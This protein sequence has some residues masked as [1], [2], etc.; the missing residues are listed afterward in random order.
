M[1]TMLDFGGALAPAT[2]TGSA[3]EDLAAAW[4]EVSSVTGRPPG[5]GDA[6]ATGT[7]S[8]PTVVISRQHLEALAQIA[9]E[10]SGLEPSSGREARSLPAERAA[11]ETLPTEDEAERAGLAGLSV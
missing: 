9:D 2:R 3:Q 5:A 8:A 4:R 10:F 1:A 7:S 11:G 6:R